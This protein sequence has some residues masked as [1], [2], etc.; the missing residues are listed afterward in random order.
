VQQRLALED[1]VRL[2]DRRTLR[3]HHQRLF[4]ALVVALEHVGDDRQ[5]GQHLR[6]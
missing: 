3:Q 1:R 5:V 2:G 4:E 6:Q